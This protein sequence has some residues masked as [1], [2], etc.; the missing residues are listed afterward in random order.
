[1]SDKSSTQGHWESHSSSSTTVQVGNNP[2]TVSGREASAEGTYD[3]S[4]SLLT[5]TISVFYIADY[6]SMV[7]PS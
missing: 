7:N 3:V 4:I 2:A 1:M 6:F 5:Y